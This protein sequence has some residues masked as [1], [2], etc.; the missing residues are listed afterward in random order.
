MKF[1]IE[2]MEEKKTENAEHDLT[3]DK[4]SENEREK[5]RKEVSMLHRRKEGVLAFF[6]HTCINSFFDTLHRQGCN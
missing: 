6:I 1:H 3:A 2:K 4:D 5:K